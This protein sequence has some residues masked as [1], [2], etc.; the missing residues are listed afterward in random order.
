MHITCPNCSKTFIA[1]KEQIGLPGRRVK[2]SHCK[3]IWFQALDLNTK[4]KEDSP[5]VNYTKNIDS[6]N[7]KAGKIYL[8][9]LLP[10]REVQNSNTLNIL[11]YII[12]I[13]CLLLS[14]YDN[15]NI[16]N[17]HLNNRSLNI[18]NIK[19][20]QKKLLKQVAVSYRIT[21][22]SKYEITIPLIRIR[23]LNEKL[24]P[25]K[26]YIMAQKNIKLE[27]RKHIDITTTLDI[28]PSSAALLDIMLGNSLD[29]V[30]Q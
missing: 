8:P 7:T 4:L 14:L 3:H 10:V 11:S 27:P 15:F 30:L 26:S 28:V 6:T 23:L 22:M 12:I 19:T 20:T 16:P 29:F 24:E 2:C 17:W 13:F 1:T 18:E 21:N 25:L 5:P 9:A